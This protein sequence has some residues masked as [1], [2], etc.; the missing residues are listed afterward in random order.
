MG[1]LKGDY[2]SDFT[3]ISSAIIDVDGEIE[4]VNSNLQDCSK[5]CVTADGFACA[6][7]DYCP[8]SKICLLNSGM[9]PKSAKEGLIVKESCL[10]YKRKNKKHFLLMNSNLKI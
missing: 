9:E 7:F 1:F 3:F 2:I 6:S 5:E 10:T 4:L 8:L